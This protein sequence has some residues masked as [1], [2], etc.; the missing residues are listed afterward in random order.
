MN[1]PC[2]GFETA[3]QMLCP[4]LDFVVGI[5]AQFTTWTVFLARIAPSFVLNCALRYGPGQI[6]KSLRELCLRAVKV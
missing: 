3:R 4:T 1:P 6:Y 2:T 5:F